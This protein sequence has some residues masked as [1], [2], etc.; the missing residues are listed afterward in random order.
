[1]S[2]ALL[3]PTEARL[4]C[5][6]DDP[7]AVI[8]G[9]PEHMQ[10][11]VCVLLLFW[12]VLGL[13][14][15]YDKAARGQSVVW[16][17]ARICVESTLHRCVV[18][19]PQKKLNDLKNICSTVLGG[20]GMIS[21][22]PLRSLAGQGSW[23]GGIVP[24]ILPFIRQIVGALAATTA[25]RKG[26]ELVYLKQVQSALEWILKLANG[27]NVG[28][29]RAHDLADR[30]APGI[31]IEV[32]ASPKGGG[33]VLWANQG[34]REDRPPDEYFSVTWTPE[35][36]KLIRGVIGDPGSQAVWEAFAFLLAVKLWVNQ[37]SGP[38][39][40]AGDAEGMLCDLIQLRGKS[41]AINEIA[42]EIA[43]HLAPQGRDLAG[44]HLWGER[45]TTADHLSRVHEREWTD[46]LNW[47]LA[48]ATERKIPSIA[49]LKL[50][51][52]T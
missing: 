33:A 24:R 21:A 31:Y 46:H 19:L 36:A 26:N 30:H 11:V 28:L 48:S 51:Y 5:F 4:Q 32:D 37:I 22:G 8:R 35:H 13:R 1:M 52:W 15:A 45:N 10:M 17:G 23:I 41:Q 39:V 29:S 9:T 14:F 20:R 34:C 47:V 3:D 40:V 49:E 25:D 50:Q 7:I 16:I 6:V 2:Q 44:L 38:I 27:F 12:E 43:L 42:K 18:D